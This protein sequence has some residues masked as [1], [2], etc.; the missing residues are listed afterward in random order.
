MKRFSYFAVEL[1]I[2]APMTDGR[3][4]QQNYVIVAEADTVTQQDVIELLTKS[5]EQAHATVRKCKIVSAGDA[6]TLFPNAHFG[7]MTKEKFGDEV[8]DSMQRVQEAARQ[9]ARAGIVSE[10]VTMRDSARLDGADG[11]AEVIDIV[12]R[13]IFNRD[14]EFIMEA[15]EDFTDYLER[16]APDLRFINLGAHMEVKQ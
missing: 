12:A 3:D 14:V 13:A 4:V 1:V 15:K 7:V 2:S 16:N 5:Y 10:I 6:S 8:A 9:A 11:A